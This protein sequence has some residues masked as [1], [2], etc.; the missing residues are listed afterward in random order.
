MRG[1]PGGRARKKKTFSY[2]KITLSF[3]TYPSTPDGV[4]QPAE[5][6]KKGLS[7]VVRFLPRTTPDTPDARPRG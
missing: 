2:L 7:G 1:S 4:G 5:M 3:S 6:T